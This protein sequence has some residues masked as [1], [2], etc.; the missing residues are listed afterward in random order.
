MG[1][2]YNPSLTSAGSLTLSGLSDGRLG[3]T[4]TNTA[5]GKSSLLSGGL[6]SKLTLSGPTL[7]IGSLR[8]GG[9]VQPSSTRGTLH[10]SLLSSSGVPEKKLTVQ[11][12]KAAKTSKRSTRAEKER[13]ERRWNEKGEPGKKYFNVYLHI[14]INI[15]QGL[16]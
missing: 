5:L 14:F 11:F 9:L 4:T 12:G 13:K 7:T 10:S 2:L 6:T 16:P 1:R 8:H 3:L 15:L